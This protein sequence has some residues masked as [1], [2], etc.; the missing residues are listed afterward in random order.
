MENP[1]ELPSSGSGVRYFPEIE[2]GKSRLYEGSLRFIRAAGQVWWGIFGATT[3]DQIGLQ[4]ACTMPN[5]DYC[6]VSCYGT[7]YIV[8]VENPDEWQA[9][10]LGP[11]L[12]ATAIVEARLLILNDFT[13]IA[14]Y[15]NERNGP[16]WETTSLCSDELKIVGVKGGIIECTGWDA[17]TNDRVVVNVD[18]FSGRVYE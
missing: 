17:A 12:G 8:N 9:V 5:S 1:T 7:G 3:R 4:L 10:R 16:L 13:R 11:V 15:G 2:G 6:F 18:V 14:A